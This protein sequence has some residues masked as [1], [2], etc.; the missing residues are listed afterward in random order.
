MIVMMMARLL[1]TAVFSEMHYINQKLCIILLLSL[2]NR[3][4]AIY[5]S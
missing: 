1:F 2:I 5:V 3:V 4:I